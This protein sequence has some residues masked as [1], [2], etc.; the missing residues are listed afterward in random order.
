[1]NM[2]FSE[3][4]IETL[5]H[6]FRGGEGI[7]ESLRAND[8]SEILVDAL[9]TVLYEKIQPQKVVSK[10]PDKTY[11]DNTSFWKDALSERHFPG[12]YICLEGFHLMEWLP[13]APGRYFTERA[14]WS[15]EYAMR[16]ISADREEYL[17]DGKA[18]M[19]QGGI[20]AIR[21]SEKAINGSTIYFLG[22]SST[23]ISHQGVP[24]A[25][26]LEEYRKVIPVIK[27]YG[28]CQVKL[29]GTLQSLTEKMPSLHFDRNVPRYCF[30][31]EEVVFQ[32]PS[33]RNL[34][35][36]TVAAMFST[37]KTWRSRNY[38]STNLDKSWTFCSFSPAS[39][40]RSVN[41]AAEWLLDYAARYS[42]GEPTILTDFDE[43]YRVFPCSVEFPISD[44]VRGTIDWETLH[45]YE[46][47][48]GNTYIETYIKENHLSGDQINVTGDNNNIVNRS[49]VQNAFNKVK[50][51][52]D[53]ETAKALIRI[54]EEINISGNKEA[55]ENFESFTDE[56]SKAEP[57]KSLLKTLWQGT[58][59]ALPSLKALTDIVD[60]VATL[61]S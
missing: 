40:S 28:G 5:H 2:N 45:V 32:N 51:A 57:K 50:A 15:R 59:V 19:V 41:S 23:G 43:H 4:N 48:Y 9:K 34:L 33:P 16:R 46:R 53:E 35:I 44:I 3:K 61:I 42:N 30:F 22:A 21:L 54:A 1:M 49:I 12:A 29:I 36:T 20:G 14:E 31:A 39:S 26:P 37:H 38:E 8:I 27:E 7:G 6:F 25:L 17:P 11:Y 55:A 18:S 24:I 56:L 60:K 10:A 52:H 58:L 47:Y 13:F